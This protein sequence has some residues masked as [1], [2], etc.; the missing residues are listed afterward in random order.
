[1][2]V[3]PRARP[4]TDGGRRRDPGPERRVADPPCPDRGPVGGLDEIGL[5]RSSAGVSIP[6]TD[7]LSRIGIDKGQPFRQVAHEGL[8]V[9]RAVADQLRGKLPKL[10]TLMDGAEH[11]VLSY[12]AFPQGALAADPQHQPAGAAERRDQAQDHIDEKYISQTN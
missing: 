1:M 8:A 7:P 12:M 5:Q 6:R 9:R 11:E 3:C 4:R 10:G 2:K